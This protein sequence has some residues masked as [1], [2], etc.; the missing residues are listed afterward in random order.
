[1]TLLTLPVFG[2][3]GSAEWDPDVPQEPSPGWED[4]I[5]ECWELN[6]DKR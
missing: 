6:P 4:A 2:Y 1:M 3:T 5:R